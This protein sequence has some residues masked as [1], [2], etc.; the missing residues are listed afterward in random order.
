MEKVID[1]F[2]YHLQQ[3][4]SGGGYFI[5]H[6]T[7]CAEFADLAGGSEGIPGV[8]VDWKAQVDAWPRATRGYEADVGLFHLP[9][10]RD[11]YLDGVLSLANPTTYPGCENKAGKVAELWARRKNLEHPVFDRNTGRR[12][13]PF[14]FRPLAFERHGYIA[15]E[16]V[17]LIQK[18]AGKKAAAFELE[19]SEEIRRWYTVLS[20]CVQRANAKILRGEAVPG[21]STGVPARLLCGR[22]DLAACG[23]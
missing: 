15:K 14:D 2:G 6:D 3:C 8:V 12:L 7:T 10:D 19:P 23:S 16:T 5:G 21:R 18:L 11:L 9:G 1:E 13:Q 22:H 4:P 20:C 17:S